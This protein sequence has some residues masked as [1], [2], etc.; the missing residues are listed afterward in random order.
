VDTD[1]VEEIRSWPAANTGC[2]FPAL[3]SY[4]T[5][6][7]NSPLSEPEVQNAVNW[8]TARGLA[9]LD[10]DYLKLT[11]PDRPE[12]KLYEPLSKRLN[13]RRFLKN[14]D[15]DPGTYVFQDTSTGGKPG[16]GP[17]SRPDF[18][19]ATIRATRFE[20]ALEITTI[21]V[22]NRAGATVKA[23]FDIRA[24]RRVSHFP[25]LACPRS[26]L[27]PANTE[28]IRA[29]CRIEDIGLILF[30]IELDGAGG[31]EVTGVKI[32]HKPRRASP[33]RDVTDDYLVS[34]LSPENCAVLQ[35]IR[36]A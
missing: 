22:K 29:T 27:N 15:I 14:L 24:H 11:E 32:D 16:S 31:C 6:R 21:E 9:K 1:L 33:E 2:D 7:L 23:V 17:L 36:G 35:A 18:T 26:L 12:L 19:L 20:K 30:D 5:G 4:L 28:E 8:L 10:G 34:R 25:Y 3:V 13:N